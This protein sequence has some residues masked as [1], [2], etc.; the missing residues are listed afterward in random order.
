MKMIF[1]HYATFALIIFA[2]TVIFLRRSKQFSIHLNCEQ[3]GLTCF[4]VFFTRQV[5][6]SLSFL[7]RQV[8]NLLS[9]LTRQVHNLLSFLTRQTH[10]SLSFLTS[11]YQK[12]SLTFIC[13]PHFALLLPTTANYFFKSLRNYCSFSFGQSI[14]KLILFHRFNF[15]SVYM[16]V[17]RDSFRKFPNCSHSSGLLINLANAG[18]IM[19][20]DFKDRK[21]HNCNLNYCNSLHR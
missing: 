14:L 20:A 9:F 6:N 8:H 1:A 4:N 5:H 18:Y 10:H 21:N 13:L 3:M 15:P 11:I 7:T 19:R 16:Y 12:I 2:Q 17:F